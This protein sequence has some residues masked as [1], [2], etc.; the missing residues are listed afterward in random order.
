MGKNACLA[1][2]CARFERV[3]FLQNDGFVKELAPRASWGNAVGRRARP[4]GVQ[5][6]AHLE[7]CA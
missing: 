3:R 4:G 5:H 2:N 6:L 7:R 1:R